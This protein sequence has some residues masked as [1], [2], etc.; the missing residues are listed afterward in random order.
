M[1]PLSYD[2]HRLFAGT[3]TIQRA[4]E[5]TEFAIYMSMAA[6]FF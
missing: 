4:A 2:N 3:S 1:L 5:A 6:V